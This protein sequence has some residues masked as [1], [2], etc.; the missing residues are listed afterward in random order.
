[1]LFAPN[2]DKYSAAFSYAARGK[3]HF[4]GMSRVELTVREPHAIHAARWNDRRH[5]APVRETRI[6]DGFRFRNIAQSPRDILD[7]DH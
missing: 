6:E 1:M 7:R 4:L 3:V 5:A 2:V